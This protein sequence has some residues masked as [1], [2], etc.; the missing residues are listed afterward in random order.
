[1]TQRIHVEKCTVYNAK[2]HIMSLKVCRDALQRHYPPQNAG[3]L[4]FC[5][6]KD[7]YI[8]LNKVYINIPTTI[9]VTTI[10]LICEFV[11]DPF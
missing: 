3:T 1:M 7:N 11:S 6:N 2:I 5:G 4:I 9:V 10:L 8:S